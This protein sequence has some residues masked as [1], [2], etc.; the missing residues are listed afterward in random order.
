M[1]EGDNRI[2]EREENEEE[3]DE[4]TRLLGPPPGARRR[5][6]EERRRTCLAVAILGLIFVTTA[7]L[8]SYFLFFKSVVSVHVMALNVWGMP[9][10][11]G[12]EDKELRIKAIGE[13]IALAEYDVYLLAELWMR[14][15]HATIEASLPEGYHM[16]AYGD[17][18]LSTCDGRML[19]SFCS[20][21]AIVS[22]FPFI[23]KQ[24]HEFN[25]HGDILK[26]DG[27]Y[28]ARKGAGRARVEPYPGTVVDFFVTHTCAVGPDYTNA[29]YR[30]RQVKELVGWVKASNADFVVLGGDFNTSPTDDESSYHDLK[31]AMVSSMEEFFRVVSEWLC[32]RRA[33]YANPENTYSYMYEP[34][35]YDYIWH[36]AHGRN[37]IWTNVFDV[38]FLKWKKF[39]GLG[40]NLTAES[41]MMSFSDHEAVTSSLYLWRSVI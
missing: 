17:F 33:T 40:K 6:R 1:G 35:L 23:E 4:T 8:A 22:K 34:V 2:E 21:L 24:F 16:S 29:Y 32:P 26:P 5:T 13:K 36:R 41:K 11:V 38:P 25:Y 10:K 27:E 31:A 15:D 19:P 9:A 12:S 3:D 28:F 30:T 14:P 7:I 39:F 18:A 20:G 37:M